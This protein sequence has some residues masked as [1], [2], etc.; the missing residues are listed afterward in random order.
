MSLNSKLDG[1][2]LD[3]LLAVA[4]NFGIK[5]PKQIIQ[6][7]GDAVGDWDRFASEAGVEKRLQETIHKT[8]R[9]ELASR[10]L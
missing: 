10:L 1:F 3:D 5:K 2:T 9:L 4:S 6:Q 7:V 8:H